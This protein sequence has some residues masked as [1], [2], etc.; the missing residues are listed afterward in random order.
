M[1]DRNA[2]WK[3]LNPLSVVA[4]IFDDLLSLLASHGV[5]S[6]LYLEDAAVGISTLSAGKS[7]HGLLQGVTL[8]SKEVVTVLAVS[9]PVVDVSNV[10]NHT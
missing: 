3:L 10:A 1:S 9:S 8:P 7:V 2:S 4:N 5:T 6:R